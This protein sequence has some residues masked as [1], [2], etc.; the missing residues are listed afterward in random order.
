MRT[1][2]HPERRL[3]SESW[4]SFSRRIL[5]DN[6]MNS[7][8]EHSISGNRE[9]YNHH[10]QANRHAARKCQL[11]ELIISQ[12]P[13]AD[14]T[15]PQA[16]KWKQDCEQSVVMERTLNIEMQKS[17]QCTRAAATRAKPVR[18]EIDRASRVKGILGGRKPVHNCHAAKHRGNRHTGNGPKLHQPWGSRTP[19]FFHLAIRER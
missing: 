19:V 16:D 7:K 1:N 14:E 15:K 6:I 17:M 18:R 13:I 5:G 3:N 8:S 12:R 11:G 9:Q 10:A 2:G 4:S